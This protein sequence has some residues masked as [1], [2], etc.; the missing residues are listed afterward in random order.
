[1]KEIDIDEE[2]LEQGVIEDSGYLDDEEA[3]DN[4]ELDAFTAA[5]NK[6]WKTA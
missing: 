2:L 3:V 1:M 5:F 6:G 4:D